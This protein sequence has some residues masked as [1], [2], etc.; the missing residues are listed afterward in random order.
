VLVAVDSLAL[1]EVACYQGR[2]AVAPVAAT[3]TSQAAV[4]T[5]LR[6]VAVVA[7]ADRAVPMACCAQVVR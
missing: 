1:V 7:D 5:M 2:R 3:T 4:A 6:A